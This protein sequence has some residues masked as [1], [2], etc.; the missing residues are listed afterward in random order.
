[1][2][3]TRRTLLATAAVAPLTAPAVAAPVD[4]IKPLYDE[5]FRYAAWLC[6]RHGLSD[7][8][9]NVHCDRWFQ[10]YDQ[11]ADLRPTTVEGVVMQ[12]KAFHRE[13][14]DG[15]LFEGAEKTIRNAIAALESL[16]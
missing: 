12:L 9:F 16:A 10:I 6:G 11:I 5:Y 8:E 15:W 2:N 3:T 14:R 7:E 13:S 1:M 4:P